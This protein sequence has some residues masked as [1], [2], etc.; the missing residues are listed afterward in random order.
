MP[1]AT[2]IRLTRS[3]WPRACSAYPSV[4]CGDWIRIDTL[5]S[6]AQL[7]RGRQCV[8]RRHNHEPDFI[9]LEHRFPSRPDSGDSG[10]TF[11]HILPIE[12][13]AAIDENLQTAGKA[14]D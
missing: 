3:S 9:L 1:Q 14:I 4:N 7:K 11:Q 6:P 12:I 10:V 5:P 2:P 13:A 8:V